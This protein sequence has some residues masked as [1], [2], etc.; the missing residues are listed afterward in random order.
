MRR[1]VRRGPGGRAAFSR[2]GS[3]PRE[4]V[5]RLD[6]VRREAGGA[7]C[8]GV[9]ID[10]RCE[11][12]GVLDGPLA[13]AEPIAAVEGQEPDPLQ[14]LKEPHVL[15]SRAAVVRLDVARGSPG[16]TGTALRVEPPWT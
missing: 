9:G 4:P 13:L 7:R 12:V 16:V 6:V 15:V 10:G 2:W 14:L 8:H 1:R 5:V 3:V 11:S